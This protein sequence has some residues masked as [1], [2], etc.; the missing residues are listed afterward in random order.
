[1]VTD[2]GSLGRT[3]VADFVLQRA[4]AVVLAL[5]GLCVGGWFALNPD[6]THA[7]FVAWFTAPAMSIFATLALASLAV[8]AWIGMWTV[9]TD[10]FRPH[11]FGRFATFARGVWLGGTALLTFVYVAWG[12]AIVWRLT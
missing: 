10:Y 1:M 11:Y 3:G 5:F 4:S 8:H 2:V 7:A 12:L 9:G 6:P